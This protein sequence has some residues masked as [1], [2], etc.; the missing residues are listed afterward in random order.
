MN[1]ALKNDSVLSKQP[2]RVGGYQTTNL[3]RLSDTTIDVESVL[4]G[5]DTKLHKFDVPPAPLVE[6]QNPSSANRNS[7]LLE[8]DETRMRRAVSSVTQQEMSRYEFPL[9]D[10][11]KYAVFAEHQRGGFHTRNN[12]KDEY[13]VKCNIGNK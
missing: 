11:Q 1:T 13:A 7:M 9:V 6:V 10:H 5:L 3:F 4:R 12:A 2:K 8:G